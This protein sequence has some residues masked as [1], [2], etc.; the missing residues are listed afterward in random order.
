MKKQFTLAQVLTVTDG[1]LAC[2]MDQLH[3]IMNHVLNDNLSTIGLAMMAPRAKDELLRQFPAL[4]NVAMPK[5][6]QKGGEA[7]IIGWLREVGMTHG[8][9]FEVEQISGP[10]GYQGL[11]SDMAYL[12]ER[13][14]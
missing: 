1:H 5:H 3:D 8:L 13:R 14:G 10:S 9:W 2:T 7:A 6:V 12:T 11:A 4:K